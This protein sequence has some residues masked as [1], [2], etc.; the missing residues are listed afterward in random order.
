MPT[1]NEIVNVQSSII[2]GGFVARDFGRTLFLT[3]ENIPGGAVIL[4]DLQDAEI[5]PTSSNSYIAADIYF[6]AILFPKNLIIA[7]WYTSAQPAVLQ[8]GIPASVA[9]FEAISDGSFAI[10]GSDI[11]NL[12]FTGLATY[13]GIA[14]TIQAELDA[15]FGAGVLSIAFDALLGGFVITTIAT[16]IAAT[17]TYAS[18]AASGTD[19]SV[20]AALTQ[21]TATSLQQGA[22]ADA[23]L[24]AA[25]N[26]IEDLNLGFYYV[27]L[28]WANKDTSAVTEMAE[29]VAARK[30]FYYAE[31]SDES[32]TIFDELFTQ[33]SN[34]VAGDWT[35]LTTTS[36][37]LSTDGLSIAS[38]ASRSGID[39]NGANTDTNPAL[40][41]RPGIAPSSLTTT[42]KN[43]FNS[44][45][46]N[47]FSPI[48]GGT[49]STNTQNIYWQGT[50]FEQFL[51]QDVRQAVDWIDNSIQIALLDLLLE[52]NKL[53]QT[54]D[55]SASIVDAIKP[56]C[57][58]AV[59]NGI[60]A[61]GTLS[62]AATAQ[63]KSITG[64]ASFNGVLSTGYLIYPLPITS[65]TDAERLQRL[66]PPTYVWIK[67]SGA[68]NKLTIQLFFDQ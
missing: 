25:M 12:D 33:G 37:T 43:E 2:S 38:A 17:L 3:E 44:K 18:T 15:V 61:P 64:N 39:R 32:L 48:G 24:T 36:T 5:F 4:A 20:L 10:N 45:L 42:Q 60:S 11:L 68:A 54:V 16:G 55:G 63:V 59:T 35:S 1:A 53:P 67:G 41:P 46:I 51:W 19:I 29:W 23:S 9:T 66:M 27:T 28:D 49:V 58:Q 65:L 7:Q 62:T 52:L 8:G 30:Y 31:S 34:R 50:T 26:R 21:Q 40:K 22:D 57:E 14:S 47:Y 56:V 6:Q 13:T